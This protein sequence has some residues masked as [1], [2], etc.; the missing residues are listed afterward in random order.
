MPFLGGRGSITAS[1]NSVWLDLVGFDMPETTICVP[2]S[3]TG[4]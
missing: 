4:R 3:T 2:I 1:K